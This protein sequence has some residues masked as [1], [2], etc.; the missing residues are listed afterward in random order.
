MSQ[1]HAK[2]LTRLSFPRQSLISR[3]M[4]NF[5][6]RKGRVVVVGVRLLRP[7]NVTQFHEDGED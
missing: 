2:F 4:S 3:I 1:F 6:N 5:A 7:V